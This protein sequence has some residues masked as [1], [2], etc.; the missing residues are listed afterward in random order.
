[1]VL[2]HGD[3]NIVS[4]NIFGTDEPKSGGIRIQGSGHLVLNNYFQDMGTFG[5]G[6][7]DGTPDDLYI[8]VS[9]VQLL[10]IAKIPFKLELI[11]PNIPTALHRLTVL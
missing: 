4:E 6:M 7:M 10:S 2:R 9:D 11:I 1:M 8:R 3:N 5:I